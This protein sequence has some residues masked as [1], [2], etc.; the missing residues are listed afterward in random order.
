MWG[1]EQGLE[2]VTKAGFSD[3]EIL[4]SPGPQHCIFVCR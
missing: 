1:T 2:M 3:I 4:D